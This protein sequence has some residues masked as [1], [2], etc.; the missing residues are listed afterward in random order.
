MSS[1]CHYIFA[2]NTLGAGPLNGT[3]GGI[4]MCFTL[5]TGRTDGMQAWTIMSC[6]ALWLRQKE[7]EVPRRDRAEIA[8]KVLSLSDEALEV[9]LPLSRDA[10][11][12]ASL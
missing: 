11:L 8:M 12:R 5:V 9:D 4:V 1:C 3:I 7:A 2:T 6:K 10:H